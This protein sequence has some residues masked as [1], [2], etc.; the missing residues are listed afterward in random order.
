MQAC[1]DPDALVLPV[2][3]PSPRRAR[4]VKRRLLERVADADGTHLTIASSEGEWQAFGEG[5]H[6]KVLREHDGVMSYLL[7]LEPGASLPAHRHPLDEECIVLEGALRV[8]SH[9]EVGAG[10]Y[11]L[12]RQGALH[13]TIG[14]VGGA[15]VFLRG[16]VPQAGHVL[17]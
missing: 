12:A 17:G 9:I 5:V 13:A 4:E 11:H 14:T 3:G 10:G 7:R 8:G 6:I 16:A 15:V 2:C 1:S